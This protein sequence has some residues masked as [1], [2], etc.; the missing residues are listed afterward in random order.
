MSQYKCIHCG[1]TY[2]ENIVKVDWG[3]FICPNCKETTD[4]KTAER[5]AKEDIW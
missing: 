1:H 3:K 4:V 5:K 2:P